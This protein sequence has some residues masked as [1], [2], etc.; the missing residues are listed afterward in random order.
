[1]SLPRNLILPHNWKHLKQKE[2]LKLYRD[3]VAAHIEFKAEMNALYPDEDWHPQ[4]YCLGT[5]PWA[6]AIGQE[7]RRRVRWKQEHPH[8]TPD[9]GAEEIVNPGAS[10]TPPPG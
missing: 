6:G 3:W 5:H 10:Q 8:P 7:L 1:M 4:R 2:L 9:K